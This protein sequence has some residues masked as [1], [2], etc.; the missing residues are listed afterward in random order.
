MFLKE[1]LMA[2][3]A[4]AAVTI[5]V[6]A[7]S[8]ESLPEGYVQIEY[9]ESTGSEHFD[10]GVCPDAQ[11]RVVCDCQFIKGDAP[12]RCGAVDGTKLFM[13]GRESAYQGRYGSI[14]STSWNDREDSG[15]AWDARR[16]V[17]DLASGSQKLDGKEYGTHKVAEQQAARSLYLFGTHYDGFA[18]M[19]SM[20]IYACQIYS[21]SDLIRDYVPAVD[22]SRGLV[23]LYDRAEKKFWPPNQGTLLQRQPDGRRFSMP[24]GMTAIEYA[25]FPGGSYVDTGV[26]MLNRELRFVYEPTVYVDKASVIG[27]S[28][29]SR[30]VHW[31]TWKN[32]YYWGLSDA[33][34]HSDTLAWSQARHEVVMDRTGDHAIIFDGQVLASGTPITSGNSGLWIGGRDTGKVFKGRVYSLK[35]LE[36]ETGDC[37]LSLIPAMDKDGK[38]GFFDETYGRFLLPSS[39]TLSYVSKPFLWVRNDQKGFDGHS[40]LSAEGSFTLTPG[41][42]FVVTAQRT[43]C[44]IADQRYVL[45]GWNL[46]IVHSDGTVSESSSEE[47]TKS[48]CSVVASEGDRCLLTWRW[49][50]KKCGLVILFGCSR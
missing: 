40:L 28:V 39:G 22:E 15:L 48:S 12:Q 27:Q 46:S 41:T 37:V 47:E 34:S 36:H 50:V 16:H 33:E 1:K 44:K 17:F 10:T 21:G 13:W 35:L 18:Y 43:S 3:A 20:R 30:Y 11:T 42:P 25:Q 26:T 24:E 5:A 32:L 6:P 14:F 31:S 9:A 8:G 23:G 19:C 38:V 2:L 29:G 4:S 7:V 49:K 45:D